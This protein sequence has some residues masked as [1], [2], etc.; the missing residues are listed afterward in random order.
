MLEARQV[1]QQLSLTRLVQGLSASGNVE[2]VRE[3]EA[4]T[5]KLSS[6]VDLSKMLFINNIALAHI[7]K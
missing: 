6:A 5:K 1:P 3:V 4:L 7:N 2:G